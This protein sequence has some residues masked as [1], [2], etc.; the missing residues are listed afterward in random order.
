MRQ[1]A[2]SEGDGLTGI[3]GLQPFQLLEPGRRAKF[4]QWPR[5]GPLAVDALGLSCKIVAHPH[6]RRVPARG[7]KAAEE[8]FLRCL[9][10]DMERL[11]VIFAR[12]RL[13]LIRIEKV[14]AERRSHADAEEL[15]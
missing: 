8:A 7:A 14:R 15:V 1:A 4:R 3:D 11:W 2:T 6:R 12:E 5:T 9:L 13:D 10:I